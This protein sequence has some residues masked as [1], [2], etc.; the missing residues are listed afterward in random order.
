MSNLV[1]ATE[2]SLYPAGRTGKDGP[3]NGTRFRTEFLVPRL[4]IATPTDKLRVVLDGC[5]SFGSSFLDEAFGGLIRY[6]GFN[7]DQ[8]GS[9]M[10]IVAERPVYWPYKKM[11][12]KY[13]IES[14]AQRAMR[15]SA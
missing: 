6:E 2:F 9:I 5:R 15:Q 10:E 7:A 12:G 13:L 4:R 3:D 14:T 8:L 1:I 11:I